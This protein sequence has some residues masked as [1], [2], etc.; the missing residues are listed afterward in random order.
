MARHVMG[1]QTGQRAMVK[2]AGRDKARNA[3]G[4][5]DGIARGRPLEVESFHPAFGVT[6]ACCGSFRGRSIYTTEIVL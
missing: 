6:L 3:Q 2:R 1:T 5:A 4:D